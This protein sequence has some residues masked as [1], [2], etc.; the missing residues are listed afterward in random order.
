[1]RAPKGEIEHQNNSLADQ[2]EKLQEYCTS[3]G[4]EVIDEYSDYEI[5]KGEQKNYEGLNLALRLFF[6]SAFAKKPIDCLVIIS[7]KIFEEIELILVR[8]ELGFY[9]SELIINEK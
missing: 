2:K 4:I 3:N 9:S 1:M 7:P 8:G 5:P 6:Y